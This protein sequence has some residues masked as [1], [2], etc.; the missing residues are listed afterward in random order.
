MALASELGLTIESLQK[1]DKLRADQITTIASNY[2]RDLSVDQIFPIQAERICKIIDIATA[3][4]RQIEL[5]DEFLR[6]GACKTM[7]STLFGM[8]STQV[9]SRK[10]FL[11]LQTIKGRLPVSTYEEQRAIYKAWLDSIEITDVRE[12]LL[13]V[14]TNTGMSMSK[15]FREVQEIERVTNVTNSKKQICA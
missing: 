9:A 11:N 10:K 8:R 5:I 4:A 13:S 15:I 6:R 2:V 7:M 12:R 14:A 3:D 1:L